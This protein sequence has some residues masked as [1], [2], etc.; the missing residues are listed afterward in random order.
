MKDFHYGVGMQ[1]PV[2]GVRRLVRDWR[3]TFTRYLSCEATEEEA[4]LSMFTYGPAFLDHY[5][6]RH[7]NARYVGMAAGVFLHMDFDSAGDPA[8]A[9]GEAQYV[10]RHCES[11]GADLEEVI[12]CFSGNKG[13]HLYFPL[14]DCA[15]PSLH[16]GKTCKALVEKL[17]GPCETVDLKIYDH[18]RIFRLPNTRH[19]ESRKLKV[20]YR[21]S[22]FVEL[23]PTAILNND[24]TRDADFYISDQAGQ[25]M[26]PLW[27]AASE[28]M[29]QK[30]F[31]PPTQTASPTALS[32]ETVDFITQGAKKGERNTRLFKA[33]CALI[34]AGI[35]LSAVQH[36]VEP[37][38]KESGLTLQEVRRTIHSAEQR[39]RKVKSSWRLFQACK[40]SKA[41]FTL[42]SEILTGKAFPLGEDWATLEDWYG[43]HAFAPPDAMN[44]EQ[45]TEEE[46]R[47]LAE[48]RLKT[49]KKETTEKVLQ[50]AVTKNTA[51]GEVIRRLK[52]IEE[53]GSISGL[54][55]TISHAPPQGDALFNNGP[56]PGSFGVIIGTDGIGKGFI[57]LDLLTGFARGDALRIRSVGATTGKRLKCCY[58][59]YEEDASD[60]K[61]RMDKVC[62]D[63]VDYQTLEETGQLR[64]IPL[65]KEG[66][67]RQS[68]SGKVIATDFL[69]Q[70]EKAMAQDSLDLVIIDPLASAGGLQD[71]N[72]NAEMA[73]L[74][75]QL[76][77]LASDT[78]CTI[79]LV[80]HTTKEGSATLDASA[81]RGAGALKG[82]SRW[83]LN[84]AQDKDGKE[85]AP[86]IQGRITK[87]THGAGCSFFLE[88]QA[89]G[90]MA[91][92]T[93]TER[94]RWRENRAEATKASY[95]KYVPKLVAFVKENPKDEITW[96]G[97]NNGQGPYMKAL[98]E[99]LS[100]KDKQEVL[101]VYDHAIKCGVLKEVSR[102]ER[103]GKCLAAP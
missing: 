16:F 72:S 89:G 55:V 25:W 82:A 64:F 22:E 13:A 99:H 19:P 11:L 52:E 46:V 88:R 85:E 90:I 80:H 63:E 27:K 32:P 54:Y 38:A 102:R 43:E 69:K 81:G 24:Q 79:L 67:F 77:K 29:E 74:A 71:E 7:S 100:L 41:Y 2:H 21:A 65:P 98:L 53:T 39:C 61:T 23:N 37:R 40:S 9:I 12:A 47:W 75:T 20:P 44:P 18:Q 66:L 17:A 5:A 68:P 8:N 31:Q 78:G 1:G 103:T 49:W 83:I 4:Y 34:E 33:A 76:R 42:A 95:A 6:T 56:L 92:V 86:F 57:I 96:G 36:L 97:I 14:P 28:G 3:G 10:L 30:T 87:N 26:A 59:S 93:A 50:E 70:L 60:L 45:F 48:E 35:P 101:S 94:E 62:A 91:E 15:L 73:F 51:P 84:L 58:I